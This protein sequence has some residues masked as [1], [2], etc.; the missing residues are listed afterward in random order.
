MVTIREYFGLTDYSEEFIERI[1]NYR[2]YIDKELNRYLSDEEVAKKEKCT[3]DDVK[4]ILSTTA[5][6]WN[7]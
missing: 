6:I 1:I 7:H 3:V 4:K 2:M 5:I